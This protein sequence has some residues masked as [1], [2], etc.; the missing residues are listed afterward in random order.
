MPTTRPRHPVTETEEISE[1]LD[2]AARRWGKLPRAK[3]IQ[4]ILDDW[5]GGGRS[6]SARSAARASLAG[7]MPDSSG[8][9]ERR[10]DWPQ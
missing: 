3:L 10:A 4:L 9:Y 1:I 8:A 6:P 7:S 2:E 5:A